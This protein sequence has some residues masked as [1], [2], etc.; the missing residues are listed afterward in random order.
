MSGCDGRL[1]DAGIV[2]NFG[3]RFQRHLMALQCTFVV[4]LEQQGVHKKG[5]RGRVREDAHEVCVAPYRATEPL[6]RVGAVDF[7]AEL[8]R[9]ARVC[10]HVVFGLAQ[11]LCAS[12]EALSREVGDRAPLVARW[13]LG[14][15]S[16]ECRDGGGR[17]GVARQ[18]HAR[19]PCA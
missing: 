16:K 12:R 2:T 3:K 7:R 8:P 4:L 19:A 17:H 11:Q 9:E 15:L 5:D 10:E 6:E 18:G 1:A 13:A 14:G